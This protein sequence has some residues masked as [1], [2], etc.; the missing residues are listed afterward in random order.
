ME[1][2]LNIQN[3]PENDGQN[4]AQS[5]G[6]MDIKKI[7]INIIDGG[8]DGSNVKEPPKKSEFWSRIG[9][10]VKSKRSYI[11]AFFIPALLLF[12][13]YA[14]FG[15]HPFGDMSVLVL[16]LNGQYVYY[17]ENLRDVLHGNGSPF[18]SWSRNL[19]GE[20]MGMFA[21]YLA[22]PFTL[23]PMLL[24]R[25]MMTESLLIMQLCKVG[26]GFRDL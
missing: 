9:K 25:S 22:S 24:P 7:N 19:S 21:Y 12:A 11:A 23:I 10:T 4:T 18:I 15:V 14:V 8:R 17:F 3:T 6:E 5:S 2:N 20:I 26:N 16:D 1:E 13:A